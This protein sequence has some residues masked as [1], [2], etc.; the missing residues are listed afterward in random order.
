MKQTKTEIET[1]I[2]K[3]LEAL[4]LEGLN[5]GNFIDITDQWWENKRKLLLNKINQKPKNKD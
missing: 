4:L 1:E 3:Y 2:E 5:S